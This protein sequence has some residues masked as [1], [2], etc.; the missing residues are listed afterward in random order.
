MVKVYIGESSELLLIH[1]K[2]YQVISVE[3]GWYR[4]VDETKEDYLYPPEQ[5]EDPKEDQMSFSYFMELLIKGRFIDETEFYFTDGEEYDYHILGY[6]PQYEKPYWVGYCDIRD[7]SE[8]VTAEEMV[9]A[10]IYDGRSIKERWNELRLVSLGG[11]C[12]NDW[13]ESCIY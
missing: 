8:F 5:F 10:K 6:L 9:T 12:L 1:G 4:I 13:R 3:R 7:G 2:E 11:L